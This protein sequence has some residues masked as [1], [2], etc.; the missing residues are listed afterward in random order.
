MGWFQKWVRRAPE[1]AAVVRRCVLARKYDASLPT[2]SVIIP[3]YNYARFLPDA[4]RSV[5]SQ[6]DVDVRV[7]IVNDASSD[8]SLEVAHS[9]AVDQRVDV[10]DNPSNV[11]AVATFNRGLEMM[12]GEFVVRLD[13][14]DMLTPGCL[15]RATQLA[16]AYPKVG[17][18]YGRPL[19]FE[20][21]APSS[22]RT[23]VRGWTIWPGTRWLMDRCASGQ[24]VITA[25]EVVMRA[26]VVDAV[27][28]QRPL[29]HA[30]DMEMWLRI[31]SVSDVAY[32]RGPHQALHREHS[33]SL[34]KQALS[35]V[36]I[37]ILE[38]NLAAF[39]TVFDE[40]QGKLVGGERMRQVAHV[41][42][43]REALLRGCHEYDRNRATCEN[44]GALISFASHAVPNIAALPEW[45]RLQR[46]VAIGE[47]HMKYRPWYAAQAAGR[48]IR[49]ILEYEY[50]KRH[51]VYRRSEGRSVLA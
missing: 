44:I 27:G 47:S 50:W 9:L 15:S 24:S 34:S 5:L 30:H 13:A 26:S 48:R 29:A 41:A 39:D 43:A 2:V 8:D 6:R 11:G 32:I 35:P 42:L 22:V 46:R 19:H 1:S 45:R 38:E 28:G 49:N 40:A 20:G 10:L 25:A 17:L 31:A 7:V 21:I 23:S 33:Y 4:V 3:C 37:R 14:D 16:R 12:S 18:I 36:G 51:G